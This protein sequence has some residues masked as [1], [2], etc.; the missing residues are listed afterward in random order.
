MLIGVQNCHWGYFS[1][2]DNSQAVVC[3]S[4]HEA[5]SSYWAHPSPSEGHGLLTSV[6][7]WPPGSRNLQGETCFSC[8][9]LFPSPLLFIILL[10]R[11]R[12]VL[13]WLR[14]DPC[15]ILDLMKMMVTMMF[16]FS[17]VSFPLTCVLCGTLCLHFT[18][19]P[20]VFSLLFQEKLI[21]ISWD[22]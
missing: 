11:G 14:S 18:G 15:T 10:S 20:L 5:G 17:P 13:C 12:R 2:R 7:T 8:A 6:S 16:R 21:S 19:Q 22:I 4:W 9:S 1:K 3:T